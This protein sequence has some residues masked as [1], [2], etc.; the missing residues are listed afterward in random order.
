MEEKIQRLE[1][2]NQETVKTLLKRLEKR[3]ASLRLQARRLAQLE[4]YYT[5]ELNLLSHAA[6]RGPI[7]DKYKEDSL[8]IIHPPPGIKVVTL[9]TQP[10]QSNYNSRLFETSEVPQ[11]TPPEMSSTKY[12]TLNNVAKPSDGGSTYSELYYKTITD[13]AMS[14]IK[15]ETGNCN[16]LLQKFPKPFK[17]AAL[18]KPS[19]LDV[20]SS[21]TDYESEESSKFDGTNTNTKGKSAN[22]TTTCNE[23]EETLLK[24]LFYKF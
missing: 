5:R 16:T 18:V 2:P 1:T 10:G 22:L 17:P 23:E 6:G 9:P 21:D 4:S 19:L 13:K 8:T 24:L 11:P 12:R 3:E 15:R 14:L 7:R 20:N